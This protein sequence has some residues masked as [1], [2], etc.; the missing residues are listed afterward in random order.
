[1]LTK[2][3]KIDAEEKLMLRFQLW[4]KQDIYINLLFLV[5]PNLFHYSEKWA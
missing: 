5:L 4:N 2:L 3:N 1:M